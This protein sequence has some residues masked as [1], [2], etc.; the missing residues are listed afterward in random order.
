LREQLSPFDIALRSV[1]R[2]LDFSDAGKAV[3]R[4]LANRNRRLF[5]MSTENALITLLR[6]GVTVQESSVDSKRDL[7]DALRSAC[8]DFIEHTCTSVAG[9]LIEFVEKNKGSMKPDALKAVLAKTAGGMGEAFSEVSTQMALYLDSSAT[10][11]IL[12]KPVSRKIVRAT[13]EVKKEVQ[14]ATDGWDEESKS[15]ALATVASIEQNVK[16]SVKATK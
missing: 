2:Q 5:S 14:A 7:E 6:E 16:A 8:N 9:D 15:E 11:S 3:A 4:F 12:L 10:Q 1:E 13:E